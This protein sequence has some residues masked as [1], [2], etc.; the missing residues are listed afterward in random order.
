VAMIM[1]FDSSFSRGGAKAELRESES[2]FLKLQ[3]FV[4]KPKAGVLGL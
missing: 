2:K 1:S 3:D 4:L